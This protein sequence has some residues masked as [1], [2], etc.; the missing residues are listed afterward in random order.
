MQR[1]PRPRRPPAR[2]RGHRRGGRTACALTGPIP[3]G[4]R[5]AAAGDPGQRRR[6][7]RPAGRRR[8]RF[9]PRPQRRPGDVLDRK[10]GGGSGEPPARLHEGA[11][12]G[13]RP[14]AWRAQF[15][16]TVGVEPE[17]AAWRTETQC[18]T[19]AHRR[20]PGRLRTGGP[21]RRPTAYATMY[22]TRPWTVRQYALFLHRRGVATLSTGATWPG[23]EGPLNLRSGHPPGLRQRP[24]ARGGDVGK[25]G[26]H[27]LGRGHE[28]A[29]RRHPW[30]R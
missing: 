24:P 25:A 17:A 28:G 29:L 26:G 7:G 8:R 16:A 22:V 1:R 19:A 9:H 18:Q 30:T 3:T 27:R 13:R 11:P 20:R 14:G 10:P 23:A 15:A 21:H 2:D 4:G 5:R 12:A 6:G